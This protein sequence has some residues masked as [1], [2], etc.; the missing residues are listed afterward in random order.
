MAGIPHGVQ[1]VTSEDAPAR[2]LE[3][4]IQIGCCLIL[5]V[6]RVG[7]PARCESYS[8][9]RLCKHM[10]NI[11]TVWHGVRLFRVEFLKL[12]LG[13]PECFKRDKGYL[14]RAL[15]DPDLDPLWRAF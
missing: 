1:G 9:L 14:W 4:K 7:K 6:W 15:E 12:F 8:R 10:R 3:G 5:N 2:A 11:T 13:R